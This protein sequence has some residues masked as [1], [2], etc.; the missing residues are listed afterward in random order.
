[1][2]LWKIVLKNVAQRKLS[3]TLTAA[4]IA[5]GVAVVVA[6]LALKAQSREG[7]SHSAFGYNLVV[8][9]KGSRL[10]LVLN[11]VYHMDR[12]PGN[13]PFSLYERLRDDRR[14]R[15]AVP[16]GV[17]DFYEGHRLIG[18]SDRFL[19]D[20]EVQPG[21]KFE[22]AA[23]RALA[24]DEA[25]LRH[26]LTAPPDHKHEGEGGTFEAVAGAQAARATGLR[27]GSTFVARH[28]GDAGDPHS[29]KWTVVGVLK[30]T[31]TPNDR[32]IFINLDSFF[33]IQAHREEELDRGKISAIV[34][35]TRGDRAAEDLE[36]EI[37]KGTEAM[38]VIPARVVV[39]LFDLIGKVDVLLL[40]VSSLVILV[41][42]VSIL[43]SIYNSMAER[44]RA[45][46]I[47]RALGARRTTIL[48]LVLLEAASLCLFGGLAG[49]ALGHV[50]TSAA[51]Q[52]LAARA[53][54]SVSGV[55]FLASEAAVLAGV[56]LLGA[57][58]G[59]LPALKAY[60]TDI[61]DGL[62]PTS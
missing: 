35:K 47:M 51:G 23:G 54:V 30:P 58:A 46:A 36:W 8:G 9:A 7:F 37:N 49:V 16:M 17:G 53:G 12:S 14:V 57:L 45:I 34:L 22:L 59:V 3:S 48:T 56:V 29:E 13:V 18:V 6:V 32:A 28:G 55:T 2:S 25:R 50:L 40:A 5:L 42:G 1:V 10:Q 27:P 44:R 52:L 43:V 11:T 26:L 20:F 62:N 21:R 31:G 19:T 24:Y 4:S 39:E 33:H 61:A 38:A 60:R 41:A 15:L